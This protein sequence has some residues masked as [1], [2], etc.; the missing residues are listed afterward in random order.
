[1]SRATYSLE[2]DTN[3]TT[4]Y[5]YIK[6]TA[7]TYTI[8]TNWHHVALTYDG[9]TARLYKDGFSVNSTAVGGALSYPESIV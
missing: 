3:A 9:T 4:L 1:M 8:D 2:M 6:S 7:I 5:G